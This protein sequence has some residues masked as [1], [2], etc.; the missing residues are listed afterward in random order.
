MVLPVFQR[1]S[2]LQARERIG[3]DYLRICFLIQLNQLLTKLLKFYRTL[4][5]K[6]Q[7][8]DFAS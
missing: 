7:L 3:P 1:S 8:T 6:M 5:C 4:L 2:Y